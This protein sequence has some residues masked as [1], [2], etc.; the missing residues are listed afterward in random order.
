M[1]VVVV[2]DAVV[3][4]VVEVV[5]IVVEGWWGWL[6]EM[7]WWG[8]WGW[9]WGKLE[10]RFCWYDVGG[11]FLLDFLENVGRSNCCNVGGVEWDVGYS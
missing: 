5:G 3:V 11:W 4:M 1:L 7:W 8:W 9:W 10:Y 2:V 6:S